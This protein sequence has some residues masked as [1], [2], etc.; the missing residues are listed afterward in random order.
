MLRPL[1]VLQ[2]SGRPGTSQ[3]PLLLI[4]N[5][6]AITHRQMKCCVVRCASLACPPRGFMNLSEKCRTN[7]FFGGFAVAC[8]MR[9]LVQRI[10]KLESL[11]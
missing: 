5:G 8:E 9:S 11:E 10:Y 2:Q 3:A 1:H 7:L 4:D 6:A